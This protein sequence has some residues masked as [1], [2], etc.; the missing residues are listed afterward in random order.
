MRR[1]IAIYHWEPEGC[2]AESPDA[3]GFSAAADTLSELREQVRSGLSF[4]F[5]DEVEVVD[6]MPDAHPRWAL[7]ADA[8]IV[9]AH[10]NLWQAIV[11]YGTTVTGVAER[12][13]GTASV[14]YSTAAASVATVAP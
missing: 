1:A 6:E 8:P 11:A 12:L 10:S 2:W 7:S 4:Y 9:S 13:A 3:P 5:D 14:G